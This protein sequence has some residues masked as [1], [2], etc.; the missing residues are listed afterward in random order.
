MTRSLLPAKTSNATTLM[1][2]GRYP[3][4][5]ST[6]YSSATP[7]LTRSPTHI[8]GDLS[9][10]LYTAL[11]PP[12]PRTVPSG[13]SPNLLRPNCQSQDRRHF[14]KS[15]NLVSSGSMLSLLL[16]GIAA[17]SQDSKPFTADHQPAADAA[18]V[19]SSAATPVRL[20]DDVAKGGRIAGPTSPIADRDYVHM[21]ELFK[22]EA[23]QGSPTAAF[24]LGYLTEHGL[25]VP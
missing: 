24:A 15:A 3:P 17:L 1:W 5:C 10:V 4:V 16:F 18:S 7:R 22:V 9:H 20:P 11:L 6:G 12:V 19:A 14:M 13:R 25:G 8:S 2:M 23:S 21:A